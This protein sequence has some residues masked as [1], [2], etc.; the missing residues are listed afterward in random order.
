MSSL[1]KY[2]NGLFIYRR[3][4]RVVDNIGLNA[5][6]TICK[7]IYP[8]FI[9]T[10]EQVT[11]ENNY[12]SDNAVQFM[13]ES[14]QDL[15]SQ[16]GGHLQCFYGEN[17]S[18]VSYLAK[19]LD[20]N[21]V[22][23][24]ADY[25]PYAIKRDKEIADLCESIGIPFVYE[26]D[27]YLQP[28][29]SI[30]NGQG[31]TYQ[32]FTPFYHACLKKQ[33]NAPASAKKIHFASVS[34]SSLNH[35]ITLETAMKQFI[36]SINPNISV[37]GGRKHALKQLKQAAINIKNYSKTRDELDKPSSLLSAYIKFGCV[38]IREIYKFF[39][40]NAVANKVANANEGFIRQLYWRDFY[41]NILYAF[42]RVLGHALKPK[43]DKIKWHHNAKWFK[44]WC[45]GET[46]FPVVDAGMRQM[47][48]T[49]YMENRARLIVM[50]FLVKTLLIDWREGETYFAT[51]L[52]D[53]DTA[54]NNGNIQ[55][56]AGTGAD[57]QQYMRIFSPFRQQE[58]HDPECVYIKKWVPEL[59][60]LDA[61]TIH[62][63][64]TEHANPDYTHISYPKPM[65]DYAVQRKKALEMY[66]G[67]MSL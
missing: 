21:V 44:K 43:Y 33:V 58:E 53:Y 63:W 12:K 52:T 56:I 2:V 46:G 40:A 14:L 51:K 5:A 36:S 67:A 16:T 7:Q 11:R 60:S 39:H 17:K 66:Q 25:T 3:D 38:S 41:A 20:I 65:C 18:I 54:S 62:H 61:K 32:K 10:P 26:H 9:F 6:N 49:G 8:I 50:S 37:N 42:P 23:T 28:I 27:Y 47:N 1:K 55:W 19:K 35:T 45:D 64:E 59:A 15:K 57:S 24:N 22:I 4:F 34:S 13:I 31:E 30:L 29:G 48:Q